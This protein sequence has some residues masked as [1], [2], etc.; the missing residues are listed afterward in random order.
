M[1]LELNPEIR[2]ALLGLGSIW[3][4]NVS[5][6]GSVVAGVGVAVVLGSKKVEETLGGVG[7]LCSLPACGWVSGWYCS[8][9]LFRVFID[10]FVSGI[11]FFH[12][13]ISL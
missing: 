8:R 7:R 1:L 9:G 5:V 11:V 3:W 2:V 12:V 13:C 6:R 10:G 4:P